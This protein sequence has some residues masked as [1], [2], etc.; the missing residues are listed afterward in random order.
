MTKRRRCISRITFFR[1]S[2]ILIHSVK[3]Y[4]E[5]AAKDKTRAEE[6]K[7]AYEVPHPF[8]PTLCSHSPFHRVRRAQE[9]VT[10]RITKTMKSSDPA[11]LPPS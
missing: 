5:Q 9:A 7:S 1:R 10:G 6:E 4:I 3:P 8:I 2:Q 11:F